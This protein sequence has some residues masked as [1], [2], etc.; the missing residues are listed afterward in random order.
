MH[1]IYWIYQALMYYQQINPSRSGK[2]PLHFSQSTPCGCI[3]KLIYNSTKAES[4]LFV[5][6]CAI[7]CAVGL[8]Q[9]FSHLKKR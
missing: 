4:L 7:H 9:S 5:L 1:W 6:Y 2:Y 3:H 8:T